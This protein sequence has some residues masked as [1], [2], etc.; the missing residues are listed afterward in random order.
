[1]RGG[2]QDNTLEIVTQK[3]II[4]MRTINNRFGFDDYC[5]IDAQRA[6]LNQELISAG[7]LIHTTEAMPR[8]SQM[9]NLLGVTGHPDGTLVYW[10]D[11]RTPTVLANYDHAIVSIQQLVSDMA[12][13]T[14]SGQIYIVS[15]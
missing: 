13:A 3:K 8:L 15:E 4:E 2:E 10:K 14:A 6:T 7:T 5:V 1:M 9:F 12:V 11:G